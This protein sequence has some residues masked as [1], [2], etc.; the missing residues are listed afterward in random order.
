M[1]RNPYWPLK[2]P[3][4]FRV[5]EFLRRGFF[6]HCPTNM[7]TSGP[8]LA[9]RMASRRPN[10]PRKRGSRRAVR[11]DYFLFLAF[12]ALNFAYRAFVAFEIF[13][14]VAAD[15]SLTADSF[16]TVG[17]KTDLEVLWFNQFDQAEFGP[18]GSGEKRPTVVRA[19]PAKGQCPERD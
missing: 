12:S 7:S 9:A 16:T 18:Q 17:F 1:Q 8:N 2:G 13:A 11:A 5:G 4:F 15:R 19:K 6:A 10:L 3:S 14:L